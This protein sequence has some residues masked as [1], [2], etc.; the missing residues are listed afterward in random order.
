ML[1]HLKVLYRPFAG[2]KSV[3]VYS[4]LNAF[5][6]LRRPFNKHWKGLYRQFKSLWLS[7]CS[8]HL[9]VYMDPLNAFNVLYLFR[10]FLDLVRHS[11]YNE[12]SVSA[13]EKHYKRTERCT[14]HTFGC[15]GEGLGRVYV[16]LPLRQCKLY[17][18]YVLVSYVTQPSGWKGA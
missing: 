1:M 10:R 17:F 4:M 14:P 8:M 7:A 13:Y 15:R 16:L 2:T 5:D 12:E 11:F 6:L 9:R 3:Y 18:T